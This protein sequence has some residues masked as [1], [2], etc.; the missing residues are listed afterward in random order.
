MALPLRTY[1]PEEIP[2]SVT[3]EQATNNL[4]VMM[5]TQLATKTLPHCYDVEAESC[6]YACTNTIF[7]EEV[8]HRAE[9]P[10]VAF[11]SNPRQDL[12]GAVELLGGLLALELVD[13]QT[14]RL[15]ILDDGVP[16]QCGPD[17][18]A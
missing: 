6:S 14:P 4:L 5:L 9:E 13:V 11:A 3:L 10:L 7:A 16:R 15:D 12:L 2:A 17:A 18:I 8:L 1:N